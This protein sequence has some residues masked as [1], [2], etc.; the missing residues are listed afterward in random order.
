MKKGSKVDI[1]F[2]ESQKIA[3]KE[4]QNAGN[5]KA[6]VI[7]AVVLVIIGVAYL[8]VSTKAAVDELQSQADAYTAQIEQNTPLANTA[9][10]TY[11]EQIEAY[12]ANIKEVQASLD[13]LNNAQTSVDGTIYFTNA[14]LRALMMESIAAD[15]SISNATYVNGTLSFT[16]KMDTKENMQVFF[17]NLKKDNSE[18]EETASGYDNTALF[19]Y[20]SSS[21]SLQIDSDTYTFSVQLTIMSV[22]ITD[23]I[24]A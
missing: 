16:L 15:V 19:N 5:G 11:K 24:S 23:Q 7:G 1:N 4:A 10:S 9:I 2:L 8:Y 14:H 18:G 3:G 12:Q 20:V 22:T 6:I 13:A 21:Y 17:N